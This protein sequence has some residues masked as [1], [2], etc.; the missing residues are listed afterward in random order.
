MT[1]CE[2]INCPIP[3]SLWTGRRSNGTKLLPRWQ[4]GVE[5]LSGY[6][7]QKLRLELAPSV[8][9]AFTMFNSAEAKI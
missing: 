3:E 5:G 7:L 4:S 9:D 6:S 1:N 2:P 8:S